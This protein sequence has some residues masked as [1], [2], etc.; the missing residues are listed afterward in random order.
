MGRIAMPDGLQRVAAAQSGLVTRRQLAEA[1]LDSAAVRRRLVSEWRLVLPGVVHLSRVPLT[2]TQRPVATA[3]MA[4]PGAV[5]TGATAARWH[6][7]SNAGPSTHVDVL[8]ASGRDRRAGFAR[9][10]RTARLPVDLHCDG[11]LTFAPAARAVADLC[12]ALR[13]ERQARAVAIEAVQRG[14]A[15]VEQLRHELHAGPRRESLLLRLAV[16]AAETGA[17]SVPEHDLLGLVAASRVLPRAW[18][19][20][21]LQ[22]ADGVRLPSPDLWFDDVGVAVQVHSV[23]HHAAG[24]DWDRTVRSDSALAEA[25]IL[26]VSVTPREI[27]LSP[28]ETLLRIEAVHGSRGPSDRPRVVMT[29]RVTR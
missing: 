8:V 15:T 27:A 6:G 9:V 25:G 14:K 18:P 3:L 23:T 21:L 20:P 12:R 17:W 26:R 24:A 19:N 4:G 1:G 5:I 10:V 13:D 29:P 16:E 11:V 2:Q 22:R 7:L 28:R